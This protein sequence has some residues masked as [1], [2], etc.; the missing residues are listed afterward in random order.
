MKSYLKGYAKEYAKSPEVKKRHYEA[1]KRF[2]ATEK[3]KRFLMNRNLKKYYGINLETYNAMLTSQNGVCLVCHCTNKSGKR[4]F[5]DHDHVTKK[6][7]GLLCHSCNAAIGLLREDPALLRL[8][9]EYL[10]RFK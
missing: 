7:R 2:Y 3:G 5:V 4:L 6:V 8:A 9:M 10:E 1:Q